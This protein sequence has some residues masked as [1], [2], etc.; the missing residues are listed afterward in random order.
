M[1]KKK[2]KKNKKPLKRKKTISFSNNRIEIEIAKELANHGNIWFTFQLTLP[3]GD[4]SK[5]ALSHYFGPFQLET[6]TRI[7]HSAKAHP[8]RI[9]VLAA[10][11]ATLICEFWCLKVLPNMNTKWILYDQ[12][13]LV[14]KMKLIRL[15]VYFERELRADESLV[16]FTL[17]HVIIIMNFISLLCSLC[18]VVFVVLFCLR[19]EQEEEEKKALRHTVR[20]MFRDE[21]NQQLSWII[22]FHRSLPSSCP[23]QRKHRSSSDEQAFNYILNPHHTTHTQLCTVIKWNRNYTR[24][25]FDQDLLPSWLELWQ[26][27]DIKL[28]INLVE[29]FHAVLL[30]WRK[31]AHT[32]HTASRL[33]KLPVIYLANGE[34]AFIFSFTGF[35]LAESRWKSAVSLCAPA[36]PYIDHKLQWKKREK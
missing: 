24:K 4:N 7:F 20:E 16:L 21:T 34:F 10:A 26:Q 11:A 6:S 17:C 28:N 18:S 9:I 3:L 1:R 12:T 27:T 25:L 8:A 30:W 19:W 13:S 31:R 15:Q 2:L 14:W 5:N 35:I 32:Q 22:F 36:P 23:F 33:I 29:K